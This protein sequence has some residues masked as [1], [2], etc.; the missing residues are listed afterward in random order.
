MARMIEIQS[1]WD[2]LNDNDVPFSFNVQNAIKDAEIEAMPASIS[3]QMMKWTPIAEGMPKEHRSFIPGYG[4][5]SNPVL[6]TFVNTT[7]SEPW[8][9][10][11]I[12]CEAISRNGVFM[13]KSYSGAYKA[14]AWM[15]KPKPY[16]P[17]IGCDSYG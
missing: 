2:I 3:S 15:P 8:P 13:H 5:V 16:D 11:C 1:L 10:N 9:N 12:V 17:S 6:V 14:I 7:C 4:T